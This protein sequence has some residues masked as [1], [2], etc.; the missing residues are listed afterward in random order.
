ME[1]KVATVKHRSLVNV[2]FKDLPTF[3]WQD[4]VDKEEIGCG[5]AGLARTMKRNNPCPQTWRL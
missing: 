4:V 1:F 3:H 5:Y 2:L